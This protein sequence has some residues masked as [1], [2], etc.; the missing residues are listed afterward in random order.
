VNP[1]E[2][3]GI[4]RRLHRPGR[5]IL[6]ERLAVGLQTHVVVLCFPSSTEA[7]PHQR[8]AKQ[9]EEHRPQID[10][11]DRDDAERLEQQPRACADE[12]QAA[13]RTT[14]AARL[15]DLQHA[16]QNQRDRPVAKVRA[17]IDEA[18]VVEREERAGSWK[19]TA[20]ER[21]E[22]EPFVNAGCRPVNGA[23]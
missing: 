2:P 5:L 22:N 11:I 15:P 4:Q 21:V 1:H 19:D 17:R 3:R 9:D 13:E 16:N 10:E 6:E 18:E 12:E 14:A 7:A 8:R 23:F 20:P